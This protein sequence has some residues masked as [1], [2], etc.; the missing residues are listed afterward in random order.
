MKA[1]WPMWSEED[2]ISS[3]GDDG[4]GKGQSE[5]ASES[6]LRTFNCILTLTSHYGRN[7]SSRISINITLPEGRKGDLG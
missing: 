4:S 3:A 2:K 1:G 6:I 7:Y 5:K